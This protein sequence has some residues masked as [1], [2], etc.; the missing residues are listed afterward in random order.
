MARIIPWIKPQE[1][2]MPSW[3]PGPFWPGMVAPDR[4]LS[5]G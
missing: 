4:A 2:L 3:P 1:R 5:M